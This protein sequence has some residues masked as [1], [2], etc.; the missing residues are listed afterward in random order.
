VPLSHCLRSSTKTKASLI[1]W[2]FLADFQVKFKGPYA[3]MPIWTFEFDL[4]ISSK[5]P[6]NQQKLR[7]STASK[8]SCVPC[9][10]EIKWWKLLLKDVPEIISCYNTFE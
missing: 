5:E 7:F 9:F 3:L 6:E 10:L 4:K 2:I 8:R 1:F